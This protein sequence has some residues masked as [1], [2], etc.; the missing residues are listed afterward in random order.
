MRDNLAHIF[1]IYSL[2]FIAIF[3]MILPVSALETE[4]WVDDD[5]P[6]DGIYYFNTIQ[7]GIYAVS[8]GGT[9]H[10]AA[11]TYTLSAL[12]TIRKN[13]SLLRED[14][15]TTIIDGNN[16]VRI[17]Y[18]SGLNSS[19]IIGGFTIQ[20]GNTTAYAG[21]I[22]HCAGLY[23][24]SSSP[25]VTN[26]IIWGNTPDAVCN[27]NS[28]PTITYSDVSG[29][30]MGMGNID[31]DP[32]F[33]D[34]A[35]N[36][37]RLASTSLCSDTGTDTSAPAHGSVTSDI[38]GTARQ[39]GN[40]YDMGAYEHINILNI[41]SGWNLVSWHG[42]EGTSIDDALD[43]LEDHIDYVYRWNAELG[44]YEYSHYIDDV[45]GWQGE[46][47]V[48]GIDHGYWLHSLDACAWTI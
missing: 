17:I 22:N 35:N 28:T 12:I 37:F 47:D 13:I 23:N 36:D 42:A 6:N 19:S 5:G 15:A 18:T 48:M 3:I 41:Q 11:V 33:V 9:V 8:S 14:Q 46:F 10:V 45:L 43:G 30:Y 27:S 20:N 21:G 2:S 38:V 25:T 29:G 40:A 26:C 39:R 16:S 31:D 7:A 34:A 24:Y 32:L 4:V 44:A 1:Y